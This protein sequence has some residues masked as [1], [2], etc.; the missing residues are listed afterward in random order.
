[1]VARPPL[2][3]GWM[4]ALA[5]LAMVFA[6]LTTVMLAGW[7]DSRPHVHQSDGAAHMLVANDHHGQGPHHGGSGSAPTEDALHLATHLVMQGAALP[8]APALAPARF[9]V[10]Q[11]RLPRGAA[12]TGPDPVS[13]ILR[14]P[15]G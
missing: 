8:D 5:G 14:P 9:A 6:L 2:T 1:M 12:S 4:P 7:H 10:V 11:P 3:P 13:A 15:R